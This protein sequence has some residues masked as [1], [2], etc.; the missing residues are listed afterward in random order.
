MYIKGFRVELTDSR[1][2]S[3]ASPTHH[4]YTIEALATQKKINSTI[5]K[6][7][8]QSFAQTSSEETPTSCKKRLFDSSRGSHP[9]AQRTSTQ[10]TSA[11]CGQYHET[12]QL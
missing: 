12:H 2:D 4:N 1:L 6:T 8:Q 11:P 10:V 9:P 3:S 7:C 5:S